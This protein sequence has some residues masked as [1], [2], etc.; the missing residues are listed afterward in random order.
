[1]PYRD[2]FSWVGV[3]VTDE[4]T[5]AARR[6]F[7]DVP[8]LRADSARI[9]FPDRS[10]D[11]VLLR[12]LLEHLPD[13]LMKATLAEAARLARRAIVLVFYIEPGA[14]EGRRTHRVDRNF[15]ET[16][17]AEEEIAAPLRAAGWDH[18]GRE[19]IAGRP[20]ES[21]SVWIFRPATPAPGIDPLLRR[22][23]PQDNS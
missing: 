9:P 12:H 13:W 23:C 4:M 17:W 2:P 22:S 8:V 16:R 20:R 18:A 21:D 14:L 5:R 15:I 10:F 11:V 3:D 1:M 7:P 19:S 6:N